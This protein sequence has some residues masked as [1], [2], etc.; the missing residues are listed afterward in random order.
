MREEYETHIK[1]VLKE[2]SP[3]DSRKKNILS[4]DLKVI[5]KNSGL[6]YT[7]KDVTGTPGKAKIILRTPEQPRQAAVDKATLHPDFAY[8]VQ[9][10]PPEYAE[11]D[12]YVIEDEDFGLDAGIAAHPNDV[13]VDVEPAAEDEEV[14]FVVD[15]KTFTKNYEEA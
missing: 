13:D 15:E 12:E 5:E 8:T 10:Q 6:E 11:G 3:F 14:E 1:N 9:E 2:L 7:I 4:P